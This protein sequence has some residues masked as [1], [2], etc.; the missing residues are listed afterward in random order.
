ML[1]LGVAAAAYHSTP[2]VLRHTARVLDQVV[3]CSADVGVR[4]TRHRPVHVVEDGVFVS[5]QVVL[6]E[7][8]TRAAEERPQTH[9]R[10]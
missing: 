2:L 3:V 1:Y 5:V 10:M 9:L 6:F 4:V 8:L 7:P